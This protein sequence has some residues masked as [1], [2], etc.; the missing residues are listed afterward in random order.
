MSDTDSS[1]L[2]RVLGIAF[3]VAV[4]V[5]GTIGQGILRTPGMVAQG[6]QSEPLMLTLWIVGGGIAMIDAMSTVEL[7][8][9]IRL[10]GGPYVFARR[11]FGSFAGLA[12]GLTDWL[13]NIAGIA[14]I[15]VVFAEFLHRLGIAT[16]VPLGLLAA[17][18]PLAVCGVQWFGTRVA[19]RSQEVGAAVK[20]VVFV[21]LIGALLLSPRGA[22]LASAGP[23]P[24]LTAIGIIVAIRAIYGTYYGWN[25]LSYFCEEVKDPA[26]S[27][28]RA[29]FSGIAMIT[30]VYVMVNIA[31]LQV[32]TTGEMADATLV[33][34]DAA[35][36]VFGPAGDTIVNIV[37]L[38]S[39]VTIV[40]AMVMMFPRVLFAIARDADHLPMLSDVAQN[41]TPRTALLVT[42]GAA[43]LLSLI[44][45]YEILLSFSASLLAAM[46]LFVNL[47]AIVMR[48]REPALDR[49]YRM[50]LFPLPALFA[51]VVNAALLAA[52]AYEDPSTTAKA[53]L[54]L[55]VVVVPV[56]ALIRYRHRLAAAAR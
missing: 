5:G 36:R 17:G 10:A 3:G 16:P 6:V 54:S 1:H 34:A 11:A 25:G 35:G 28:A 12:T 48:R 19:G 9:S 2:L 38:I 39:V 15:S 44:G 4:V 43:A 27:I 50:P 42:A 45:S 7:A 26:R 31:C 21:V 46:S 41:G 32:L 49:P 52:F 8:S 51:M 40:N 37:S 24:A 56:H 30:L 18:L 29:T 14:F 47:A 33:A 23:A 13:G 55:A 22:P 20:A 53:F